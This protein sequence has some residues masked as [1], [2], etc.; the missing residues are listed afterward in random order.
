MPRKNNQSFKKGHAKIGGR[1]IGSENQ[2][3]SEVK[4]VLTKIFEEGLGGYAGFEK[5]VKSKPYRTDAF[6]TRIWI[7]LLGVDVRVTA[8]PQ[9]IYDSLEQVRNGFAL[10]GI[11]TPC[12]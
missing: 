9:A 3:S 1:Q 2:I 11:C 7:K 4:K 6:Y 10:H 5:W 12:W 8:D